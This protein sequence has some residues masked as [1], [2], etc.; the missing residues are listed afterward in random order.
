[1]EL[2][3]VLL[4]QQQRACLESSLES[5]LLP[6]SSSASQPQLSKP[7]GS[8]MTLAGRGKEQCELHQGWRELFHSIL[9]QVVLRKRPG[10]IHP[11]S[12]S[13]P[14]IIHPLW[15]M[16]CNWSPSNLFPL[17]ILF[18]SIY[19][20]Y[21]LIAASPPFWVPPSYL[22]LPFFPP[23]LR[24]EVPPIGTYLSWHIK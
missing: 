10:K 24:E 17:D 20:L 21:I 11:G 22:P 5:N 3:P 6:T 18:Y 4:S 14:W 16:S 19:S 1:M 7:W 8:R 23:L 12:C 15:I 2:L 13:G 9:L